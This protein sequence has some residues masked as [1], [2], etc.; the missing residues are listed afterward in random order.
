M[1]GPAILLEERIIHIYVEDLP[2]LVR[3]RIHLRRAIVSGA[4]LRQTAA[5]NAR[6]SMDS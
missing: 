3:R 1:C 5:A 4:S 2:L 6:C